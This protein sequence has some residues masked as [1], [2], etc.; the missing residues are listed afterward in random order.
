MHVH[1]YATYTCMY[2]GDLSVSMIQKQ[3][4]NSMSRTKNI[5]KQETLETYLRTFMMIFCFFLTGGRRSSGN[6]FHTID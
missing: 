4:L 5:K 2:V 1:M 6:A 3:F